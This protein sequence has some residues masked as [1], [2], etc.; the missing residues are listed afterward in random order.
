MTTRRLLAIALAA[1]VAC[2]GGSKTPP[3]GPVPPPSGETGTASAQTST[4][5]ATGEDAPLPLWSKVKKGKLANGLT[6]Y[7]LPHGKP[8]KR[9]FLWLAV[10]AGSVQEDN[11]Q[12]GL[13]HFD[14]HMA[15]NGTKRFPEQAIITYLEKIGMGFGADLNASTSFDETIYKLTV[16]T[17]NPEFVA[18]GLD[19]LRDWAGDV[20]FDKGEV[21]KER[22]VVLEEW[23]LGRGAQLRLFDKHSKVLFKGSRYAERLPIGLPEIIKNAPPAAHVRYY[24]DWYRP[25]LMAVIA[26]GDVDPAAM[27]KEIA[28]RFGDLK[29]PTNKRARPSAGVPKADGTRIS[30]ETDREMPVSVVE[31]SNVMPHLPES[32][33]KDF[34]RIVAEQVYG[35]IMNERL[36]SLARKADAPF[37]GA[38]VGVQGF[39]REVS[40]F[41]R[42]AAAKS[43]KVED[44]LRAL[45]TEV[46]RVEKHGFTQAELDRA[47][48]SIKRYYEQIAAEAETEES[49]SYV[50]EVT[51]NFFE[52]E[53]MIGRQA[54]RDLTLEFLPK[55]TVDELN[56]LVKTYGGAENRVITI[57]GPE[58]AKLPDAKRVLEIIAEVEKSSVDAWQEKAT[59]T[60]LMTQA[61]KAGTVT[62]ETQIP[63]IGVTEWTLSNGA[64][65]VLKPTDFEADRVHVSGDSPGG[66]ALAK[67]YPNA[68]FADDIASIG[69]VATFDDEELDKM[70]AGKQLTVSAS[71]GETTESV[72][73]SASSR[74]LEAMFQLMYLRMT[75]PRKDEA[76]F[77]VWQQNYTEQLQNQLKVPEV[78]FGIETQEVLFKNN[79]RRM[80]PTPADIAKIDQDKALAF[81]KDRFGDATD[82]TFTIVGAF[83]PAKIKPLVETYLASL[84]A[85]GRKEKEKDP[86]V[87]RAGGVVKKTWNLGSEPK[88]RVQ[89]QFHGDETW[90]RDKDRDMYVLGHVLG[91]KLREKLR[92]DMG[93]VYGV[94]AA[95]AIVRR[96]RGERTFGIQFGCAPDAVDKLVKASFEEAALLA[97]DG[98]D[99]E[100]LD[101]VKAQ[102]LRER[103]TQLK[104]NDFWL[105]WLSSAYRFGDDPKLILDPSGMIARMTSDNVKASAKRFLDAKQYFQA[106]LMPAKK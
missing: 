54:E 19:I 56:A 71:I 80:V 105:G 41:S 15:F 81:Y 97:K 6:Y 44:S 73:A 55:I 69:G 18:K 77:K 96:P 25:D 70:L 34:R 20:T 99:G 68:R 52:G 104:D 39:V 29:N 89:V 87:R 17:D 47:R 32:S 58:G 24:K 27:E 10:N 66:L 43:G 13:A 16:P 65:V 61:P 100:R 64:K 84:P 76:M 63:E 42:T 48:A 86:G 88:A 82:F 28:A 38:Q 95:G 93:G 21:E 33:R 59:S 2:G 22:G 50:A 67:D 5:P 7:I 26:V 74:D 1:L 46:L 11:D 12:R 75:A 57:S 101:K 36:G 3:S 51:R 37:M 72:D 23:R 78:K 85:K 45:F 103:E 106:V 79:P 90:T 8:E 83:E 102:F 62:K 91:M 94:G 40:F 92:E 4:K 60:A 14:E 98:V 30:I 35:Q 53:F 31:V 49:S 9:A